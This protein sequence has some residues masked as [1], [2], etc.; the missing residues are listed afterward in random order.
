MAKFIKLHSLVLNRGL[1]INI[2]SIEMLD[3]IYFGRCTCILLKS[4]ELVSVRESMKEITWLK[5][6]ESR[7]YYEFAA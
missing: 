5:K 7:Q 2:D 1:Y 4:G 3:P 6:H